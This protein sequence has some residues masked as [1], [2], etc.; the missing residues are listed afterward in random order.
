MAERLGA[1]EF[2][3][4]DESGH[5]IQLDRP[6]AVVDAVRR[7]VDKVRGEPGT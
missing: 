4:V 5:W 6:E 7:V 1:S 3:V 2:V